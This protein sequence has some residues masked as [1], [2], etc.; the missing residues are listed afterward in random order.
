MSFGIYGVNFDKEGTD[1]H[2]DKN[3]NLECYVVKGKLPKVVK[4]IVDR[5]EEETKKLRK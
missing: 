5:I 4:S 3:V 2:K 1:N